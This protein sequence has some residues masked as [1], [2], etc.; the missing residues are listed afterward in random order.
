MS[1]SAW[2][3]LRQVIGWVVL[4][5]RRSAVTRLRRYRTLTRQHQVE[6]ELPCVAQRVESVGGQSHDFIYTL[7]SNVA[8]VYAAPA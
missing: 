7:K 2:P 6:K 5:Q 4:E 1:S 3:S 8:A